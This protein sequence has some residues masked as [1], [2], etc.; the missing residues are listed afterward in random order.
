MLGLDLQHL[1]EFPSGGLQ[2]AFSVRSAGTGAADNLDA[3]GGRIDDG[4]GRFLLLQT[5]DAGEELD[6]VELTRKR[7]AVQ[8]RT[9][10]HDGRSFQDHRERILDGRI[11][12]DDHFRV[13]DVQFELYGH[14]VGPASVRGGGA[15][16]QHARRD[17]DG[18]GTHQRRRPFRWRRCRAQS[19][20][21]CKFRSEINSMS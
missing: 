5:E 13:G 1:I 7:F 16:A 4:Q 12:D 17:H 3:D 18:A 15:F 10:G 2:D 19:K 21:S 20:P 11:L 8:V 14:P 6:A 9:V